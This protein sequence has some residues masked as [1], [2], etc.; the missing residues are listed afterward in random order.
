MR[1][2]LLTASSI[3][4]SGLG[5]TAA[6]MMF[7]IDPADARAGPASFE[8]RGAADVAGLGDLVA[9]MDEQRVEEGAQVPDL[10]GVGSHG[11]VQH[12]GE[13][14]QQ[15][16]VAVSEAE[17]GVGEDQSSSQS[18]GFATRCWKMSPRAERNRGS[19]LGSASRS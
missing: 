19:L 4:I 6:K 8:D 16:V 13:E 15:C 17:P 2:S 14:P 5:P 11:R 7:F 12:L 3:T 10:G 18:S 9:V 1:R